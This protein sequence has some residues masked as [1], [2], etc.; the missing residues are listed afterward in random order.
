MATELLGVYLNDHLAAATGGMELS[1]RMAASAEPGSELATAL[2]GLTTEITADRSALVKIMAS[3]GIP[4]RGYK[5]FAAWAGEKAG[6]LKLNGRLLARSPLSD[7]EET[8]ILRLGV[9][10]KAAGWRTLRMLAER[11]SRL[12]P[13]RLDELLTRADH[14]LGVLETLRSSIAERVLAGAG[15]YAAPSE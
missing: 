2:S 6:R 13:R 3:L 4:V 5:V 8:E 15:E 10:G 11:D 12:D 14:Q 1:R 9:E 7:L